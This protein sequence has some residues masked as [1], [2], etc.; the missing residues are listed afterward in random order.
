MKAVNTMTDHMD[1]FWVNADGDGHED[2]NTRTLPDGFYTV[3]VYSV[4]DSEAA[5]RPT[6]KGPYNYDDNLREDI[7]WASESADGVALYLIVGGNL[8]VV[9][10]SMV[11]IP[12]SNG[13]FGGHLRREQ[14]RQEIVDALR[15]RDKTSNRDTYNTCQEE[16]LTA[17]LR[18]LGVQWSVEQQSME[19]Y[20]DD[21]ELS[22]GDAN[23]KGWQG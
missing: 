9:P 16:A 12:K 6:M 3:P 7:T 2:R 17:A 4:P 20:P 19:G 11:V 13:G 8:T 18:L 23:D 10:H 5:L 22:T 14:V 15:T 1:V 21:Y